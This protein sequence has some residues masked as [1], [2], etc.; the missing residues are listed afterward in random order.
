MQVAVAGLPDYGDAVLIWVASFPRSGNTFLRIVLHRRY[1]VSTSVIY[2]SDGVAERVGAELI[3]YADRPASLVEMRVAFEPHFIKTHRPY[4]VEVDSADRAICLV[5]DGRDALVS[6]ARMLSADDPARFATVLR[7]LVEDDA[8]R[9]SR[10]W[11]MNVLSWL[12]QPAPHRVLLSYADLIADPVTAADRVMA[13]VAPALQPNKDAVIPGFDELRRA[14][15]DFFRR[16]KVGS[17]VDEFPP[18]L[19]EL[20]WARPGNRAAMK[21]LRE[22]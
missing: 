5:R 1:G 14:D 13:V 10:S 21:L 15:P 22:S 4:G 18:E 7:Q 17:H 11:G 16:G 2:D 12:Q 6:W 9:S 8:G 19:R 20:F 3:G